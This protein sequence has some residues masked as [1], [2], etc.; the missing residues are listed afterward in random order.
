MKVAVIATHFYFFKNLKLFKSVCKSN[1]VY[2][3]NELKIFKKDM[4]KA[5][6]KGAERRRYK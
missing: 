4:Q 1:T 3:L 5:F 2:N 6:Q